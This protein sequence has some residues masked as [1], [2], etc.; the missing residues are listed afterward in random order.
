MDQFDSLIKATNLRITKD[1]IDINP[2]NIKKYFNESAGVKITTCH[3]TKG[4]EYQ[5]VICAGLL[6]GKIPHWDEIIN[7]QHAYS[8]YM[9]KRLLYVISSRAKAALYLFSEKGIYTASK[10]EY[11]PTKQL[12]LAARKLNL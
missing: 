6:E 9:A 1:G 11:I 5:V 8:E 4:E 10:K 7:Q 2:K 3:S 12:S